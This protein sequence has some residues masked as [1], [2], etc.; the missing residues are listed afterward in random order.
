MPAASAELPSPAEPADLPRLSII[1][2][3]IGRATLARTLA[4]I[5]AQELLPGDEVLVI[6]DGP[7]PEAER[8]F[9][10]AGLPGRYLDGPE[11]HNWGGAQRTFAAAQGLLLPSGPSWTMARRPR[12]AFTAIRKHA[13]RNALNVFRMVVRCAILWK[14][15]AACRRQRQHANADRPRP[16]GGLG[17]GVI[18]AKATLTLPAARQPRS[19]ASSLPAVIARIRP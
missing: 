12:C 10:A 1:I 5:A 17:S 4:T 14:T 13:D 6:G 7:Q 16:V 18:A 2:P 11:R 8:M 19:A 9:Q 15:A 3:T